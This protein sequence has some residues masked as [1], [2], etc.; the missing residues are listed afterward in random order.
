MFS[1]T[2]FEQAAPE[3]AGLGR[4]RVERY[5]FMLLGTVRRDGTARISAVEVR[6][7]KGHLAMS[8]IHGS[9]KERD[10]RRD[11]RILLH[12]PM[13]SADDPNDEFK[14]RGRVVAIEDAELRAAA[15]VWNPP[16]EL[17]P[18]TVDIESAAFLAWSQGEMQM[19][20]WSR[21]HGLH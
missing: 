20:H 1:W 13:L 6:L 17:D 4:E 19:I 3:L 14:L 15:A 16:P 18:F 10:V 2:D 9:R 11:L 12:S 7:V 8:F 5:G 21:A